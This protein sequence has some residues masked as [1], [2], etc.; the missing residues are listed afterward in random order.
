MGV[1]TMTM[2]EFDRHLA[3]IRDGVADLEDR[4]DEQLCR[5]FATL[6]L[7]IRDFLVRHRGLPLADDEDWP[8]P[9]QEQL[10]EYIDVVLDRKTRRVVKGIAERLI[11]TEGRLDH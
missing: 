11:R 5:V 8:G 4:D 1:T 2:K 7:M 6:C 3:D 9:T 10:T